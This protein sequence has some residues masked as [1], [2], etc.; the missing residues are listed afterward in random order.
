[1]TR[2]MRRGSEMNDWRVLVHKKQNKTRKRERKKDS[3]TYERV[4]ECATI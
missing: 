4:S 2:G 1:M 3:S